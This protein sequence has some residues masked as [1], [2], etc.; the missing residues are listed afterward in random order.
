MRRQQL[1]CR[2]AN[3]RVPCSAQC[4]LR[5]DAPRRRRFERLQP[6][7]PPGAPLALSADSWL[8]VKRAARPIAV[9]RRDDFLREL[10]SKLSS[11]TTSRDAALGPGALYRAIVALQRKYSASF[12]P[13]DA[14]A[15]RKR[16]WGGR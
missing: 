16:C 6:A 1:G 9:A 11:T 4:A 13:G 7:R 15:R 10:A 2:R 14:V 12:A 8:A 3:A 5:G